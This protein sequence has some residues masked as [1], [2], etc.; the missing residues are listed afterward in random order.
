MEQHKA[1]LKTRLMN[2]RN[3][4]E[5]NRENHRVA[6]SKRREDSFFN[7]RVISV[8]PTPK[9]ILSTQA[10][11]MPR[12][13]DAASSEQE[14]RNPQIPQTSALSRRKE[15]LNR[16]KEWRAANKQRRQALEKTQID[17]TTKGT[18]QPAEEA[19]FVP[20][21]RRSL[22]VVVDFKSKKNA[23]QD[24][25]N[26]R[27]KVVPSTAP[28]APANLKSTFGNAVT[29]VNY[30]HTAL[31]SK[32]PA[33]AGKPQ[34]TTKKLPPPVTAKQ[35]ATTAAAPAKQ[36]LTDCT[37]SKST[38]AAQ[39]VTTLA[40]A[41]PIRTVTM[42]KPATVSAPS[43][44]STVA[45]VKPTTFSRKPLSSI[46]KVLTKPST[47]ASVV[48][49]TTTKKKLD[50]SADAAK[51]VNLVTQPFDKPVK[52]VNIV[53]PIRGGGGAAGKFKVKANPPLK[54]AKNNT[55]SNLAKRMKVKKADHQNN[56]QNV[57]GQLR[58]AFFG[59]IDDID[60]LP[61]TPLE[62]LSI[63]NPFQATS[64]QCCKTTN[65]SQD[66]LGLY[67]DLTKL[68]P[69]GGD[70][71]SAGSTTHT[72]SSAKR[73]LLTAEIAMS[74][75]EEQPKR[76]FDFSR[77][78]MGEPLLETPAINRSVKADEGEHIVLYVMYSLNKYHIKHFR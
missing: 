41:R 29:R 53:K 35:A 43:T 40:T 69:L 15:Y 23:T 61:D 5:I 62:R 52:S 25:A 13:E 10:E 20:S 38:G 50:P 24:T 70:D 59:N 18:E 58:Q 55:S 54:G 77:Y 56:K 36:T 71:L 44:A 39:K 17:Q 33:D 2:S 26:P 45:S 7:N 46:N 48:P 11:A 27:A 12:N 75:Q 66:L 42:K 49:A 72:K 37:D 9:E 16:F 64:T 78:S 67:R 60:E 74:G 31:A 21:N 28:S 32:P 14:N 63:D 68:S 73:Q 57:V 47:S 3:R 76:K 51:P 6:R 4:L 22:Y 8:S 1:M 34:V 65:A 19:S 30:K